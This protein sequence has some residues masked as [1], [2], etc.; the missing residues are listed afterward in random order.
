MRS[1]A[2]VLSAAALASAVVGFAASAALADP[3]AEVSPTTGSPGGSVTVSVTCEST[4]GPAPATLEAT[5]QAFEGGT[6]Q[7]QR[8][9]DEDGATAPAR[10]A[11]R[12]TAR[13][14][15]ADTLTA[16]GPGAATQD[17]PWT[18][19]G[20]CPAVPGGRGKA[21]SA[22]FHV[23]RGDGAGGGGD[24][25]PGSDGAGGGGDTPPGSDGAGIIPPGDDEGAVTPPGEDGQAVTPPGDVQGVTRPG[26]VQGV[27]RPGEDGQGV[28][29]PGEDGQ[30]VTR[31]GK[32]SDPCREQSAD[33]AD[34][35]DP[36]VIQRGVRAGEGGSFTDSV[37]AL[38]AGGILIAG[39][40]GAAAYRLWRRDTL[41]GR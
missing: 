10:A 24:T 16:D 32:D 15:A 9:P 4:G 41:T 7:L 8:V 26:D 2:R 28:T 40:L 25:R 36:A 29:R 5:S 33:S 19:D 27:T 14:A 39:A 13:L 20:T 3:A 6:V 11:Y 12:G 17:S 18:V 34:S 23:N 35:C 21:W 22:S 1:T 30:G 37:P 38:V 31:P